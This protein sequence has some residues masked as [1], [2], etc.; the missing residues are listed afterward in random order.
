MAKAPE[1]REIASTQD[2]RDITR[3]YVGPL[4]LMQPQDTVLL[5][6]GGGDL[7]LYRELYRDDQVKTAW[8]QR[9]RAV[10]S[11]EWEVEAGGSRRQDK[12]A[13][14][15]LREQLRHIGW[16]RVTEQML[17]GIFYGF[18]VAEPMWVRDGT[19]VALDQI[20][21]RDRRRFGFDGEGRLRLRTMSQPLGE[22][23]P[24][25]KFWTFRT[26][27]D[28]DD[29][30]YGLGLG[31][32]LYWPVF[33]KR[34]GIR[35][36]LKFLDKFGQPTAHGKFGKGA[37]EAEKQKLLDALRAIHT[38]TGV[39]TPEDMEIELIEAAR[40]G[41]A[42]YTALYDRMNAAIAKVILGQVATVEGTPGR[43]GADDAQ[44]DVR[45]DIIK[46]DA[47]VVCESFNRQIARWLTEWNYPSARPP[48]VWRI[49][50]EPEDLNRLAER[51]ER[52]A[53][54]GYRPT[55][56]YIREHYG[57]EW[58]PAPRPALGAGGGAAFAEDEPTADGEEQAA[59]L[60]RLEEDAQPREEA[61]IEAIREIVD[62]AENLEDL[63]ARLVE[64]M[65]EL[66]VDDW[67]EVMGDALAAAQLAGRYDLLE[68]AG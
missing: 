17:F 4:E 25:R 47:D 1:T 23:L 43:L 53:R 38:D 2:G 57:D 63:Q 40:S 21:V 33:F 8:G 64:R 9:Q 68:E 56:R 60:E 12:A 30:P 52:V 46:A 67:A 5:T 7:T 55:L 22:L 26:G 48:R 49:T 65:S 6:R 14:E 16:D 24:D 28:H 31:H 58:E 66:P 61:V 10:V 35:L 3:G 15:M 59:Q 13:A 51:D 20:L 29:E 39:V 34:S 11:A 36:W 37:T 42:D 41:T 62:Q 50:E 27:A 45:A 32:W 44:Q 18:A 54:L 19:Q